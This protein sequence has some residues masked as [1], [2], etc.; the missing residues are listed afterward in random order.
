LIEALRELRFSSDIWTFPV[1][2]VDWDGDHESKTSEDRR[3]VLQGSSRNVLV[4]RSG[5][6]RSNTG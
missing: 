4:K 6:Q 1:H 2:D 5:V 3:S